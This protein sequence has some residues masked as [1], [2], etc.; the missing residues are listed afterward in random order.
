MAKAAA[1]ARAELNKTLP[2]Y[3]KKLGHARGEMAWQMAFGINSFI[4]MVFIPVSIVYVTD[5]EFKKK[6]LP[7]FYRVRKIIADENDFP[8]LIAAKREEL[9]MLQERENMRAVKTAIEQTGKY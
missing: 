2:W 4:V 9:K 7:W 5:A 6:Y 3:R 1:A 8:A